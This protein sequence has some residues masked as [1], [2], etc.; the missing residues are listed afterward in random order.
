MADVFINIPDYG[1]LRDLLSGSAALV[2]TG[3]SVK[4]VTVDMSSLV[5]SRASSVV[6][7][8]TAGETISANQAVYEAGG[9]VFKGGPETLG[10][11]NIIGVALTA[12]A[13]GQS[14][15]VLQYGVLED[16]AF[17]WTATDLIFVDSDG[18]LTSSA[19]DAGYLTRV[20]KAITA[21]Q[22]LVN[23]DS[24]ITL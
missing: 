19:P 12:G 4:T 11:A 10:V 14:I 3:G 17:A 20:G 24:P 6:N 18:L 1:G 7:T 16:A 15:N 5:A 22:I 21:T 13:V 9:S 8:Y 23:I 2:I